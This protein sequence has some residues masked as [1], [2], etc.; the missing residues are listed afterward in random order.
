MRS[1]HYNI[2]GKLRIQ[3]RQEDGFHLIDGH[4]DELEYFC[5]DDMGQPDITL[6]IHKFSPSD[7][8]CCTID[9]KYH[10][11]KNYFY[12]KDFNNSFKW[13]IEIDGFDEG[14]QNINFHYSSISP[15]EM[16]YSSM[17]PGFVL[18]PILYKKLFE[19]GLFMIHAAGV[20]KDG[21]AY[22]FPGPGGSH[23][24]ALLADLLKDSRYRLLGDDRVIIEK[25][26]VLSFPTQ[27]PIVD[28]IYSYKKDGHPNILDKMMARLSPDPNMPLTASGRLNTMFFLIRGNDG[29]PAIADL[30]QKTA[31]NRLITGQEIEMNDQFVNC[32]SFPYYKYQQAYSYIFPDSAVSC[33]RDDLKRSFSTLLSGIKMY[34]V[35]MPY[36]YNNNIYNIINSLINK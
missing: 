1:I 16:L 20:V 2:H 13:E 7:E 23:K 33:Y 12:C 5:I 28:H 30:D 36:K 35:R 21:N 25:D 14:D 27:A 32:R 29:E 6:N 8:G 26:N 15:R 10:V 31:I 24:A 17:G 34:E 22:I 9:N 4:K 11:K 19:N 18:W 3:V